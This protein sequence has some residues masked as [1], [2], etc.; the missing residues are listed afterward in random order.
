VQ[1]FKINGNP[2]TKGASHVVF[3]FQHQLMTNVLPNIMNFFKK[4]ILSSHVSCITCIMFFDLWMSYGGHQTFA[5]VVKYI[6]NL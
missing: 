6:T 4:Y 2:P 1:G 5:M 3:T